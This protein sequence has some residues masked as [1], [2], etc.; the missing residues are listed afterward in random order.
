MFA[1]ELC[2]FPCGDGFTW[3]S[4]LASS[5]LISST[6]VSWR[7]APRINTE[8]GVFFFVAGFRPTKGKFWMLQQPQWLQFLKACI[9]PLTPN[10]PFMGSTAPLTSRGC[11]LYIYW[12]N[13]R[14]DYLKHAAQSQFFFLS[15][16]CSLFRNATF[17]VSCIVHIL[18]TGCAKI[19]KTSKFYRW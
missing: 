7:S 8:I 5:S 17:F 19:K 6:T 15:S 9:N 1:A 13:I 10:G 12:T 3:F 4:F 16:K 2:Q 14:T 11:I 18:N